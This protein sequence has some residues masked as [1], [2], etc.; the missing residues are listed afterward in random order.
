MDKR[1]AR[2]RRRR[3]RRIKKLMLRGA[4]SLCICAA[5][6]MGLA[7]FF[8]R[9]PSAKRDQPLEHEIAEQV[10]SLEKSASA[11]PLNMSEDIRARA[12]QIYQN[13]EKFLIL[14]NKDH[15]LDQDF[16][17]GLRSIC[18]R[19][20]KA[21]RYLYDDLTQMLEGGQQQGHQFWVASAYRSRQKQQALVNTDVK[22]WRK[23]GMNEEEA[24]AKTLET[25][26]PAGYSEHETGFAL[27]ILDSENPVLDNT[28]DRYAGN[29]WLR[30]HCWEYGF[31]LRYPKDKEVVT[32]IA[33]E[34]WHFR[35][36]GKDAAAFMKE[37]GLTLEEFWEIIGADASGQP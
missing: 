3:R 22:K 27:D 36:V 8:H 1:E 14:V 20:L 25:V 6:Y 34:P 18:N 26:M 5:A 15:E 16:D 13:N 24:L 10:V 7:A 11:P 4:V 12:L 19:R 35:Y 9:E 17:P 28:Q 32:G 29:Q 31:V 37:Q 33:Y 21:S 2:R 23:T 30:E